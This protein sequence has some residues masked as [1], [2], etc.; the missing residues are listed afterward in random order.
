M[1][2]LEFPTTNGCGLF[3]VLTACTALEGFGFVGCI[4]GCVMNLG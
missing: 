4:Y 1:K 3:F 2:G